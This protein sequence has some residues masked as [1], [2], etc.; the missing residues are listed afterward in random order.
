M[1]KALEWGKGNP[2]QIAGKVVF[3]DA[4]SEEEKHDD[5]DLLIGQFL[6][7]LMIACGKNSE[8]NQILM[9]AQK[10]L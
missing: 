8:I 1:V 6:T 2:A 4:L 9:L 7:D 10:V 5:P 3:G